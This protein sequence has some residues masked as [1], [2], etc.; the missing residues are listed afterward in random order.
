MEPWTI[1]LSFWVTTWLMLI[2]KTYSV[3][4]RLIAQDPRGGYLIKHRKLHAVVYVVCLFII[5]PFI[6][7]VAIFEESRRKWV[8]AYVDGI[9]GKT[10]K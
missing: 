5:A 1:L 6:W 9:L 3:S 8:L 4:M 2:W 7:Q 10:K